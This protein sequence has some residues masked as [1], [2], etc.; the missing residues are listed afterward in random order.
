M[1]YVLRECGITIGR[2]TPG[3][4]NSLTDV[5]GVLVGHAT[6]VAGESVRTGVTAIRPHPGNLHQEKVKAAAVTLN[7]FGKPVGLP[8]INELGTIE[9]PIVITNTL[10][11]GTAAD[12]LVSW[13]LAQDETH[14]Q[15]ITSLNPVVAECN[16]LYL[17]DIRSRVVGAA[18]ILHAIETATSDPVAEGC[19]GAGTGMSAFEFKSGIGSAS[20]LVE[21]DEE[22]YTVGVL[23]VP[24]FGYREEL[25]LDGVRIGERLRE[26]ERGPREEEAG[27][28]VIILATDL[29]LSHRQLTRIAKRAWLG[30]AR[31]GG[32]CH[33]GSGEFVIAFS[34]ANR[35]PSDRHRTFVDERRLIDSHGAIDNVFQA[36]IESVEESIHCALFSARTTIGRDGHRRAALPIAKIL[37]L[38]SADKSFS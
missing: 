20:R 3:E 24:N 19:C 16:D 17:N 2:L 8:Q 32:T 29:P 33:H 1:S 35:G 38:F 31:T 37:P 6:V 10:S 7:G 36:V 28:I 23:S 13:S 22:S 18:D 15:P 12:A 4:T 27:S 9:V 25:I 34:T 21:L 14:D 26:Y 11:V 30:I 5:P